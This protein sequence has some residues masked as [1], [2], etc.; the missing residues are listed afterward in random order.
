M[1]VRE[2][3]RS[4]TFYPILLSIHAERKIKKK[5]NNGILKFK[6]KFIESPRFIS[7]SL[8]SLTDDLAKVLHSNL[9]RNVKLNLSY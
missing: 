6:M 8:S 9:L 4:G 1:R 2:N 3:Q 7:S 5:E